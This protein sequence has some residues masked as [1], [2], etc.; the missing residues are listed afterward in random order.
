MEMDR[1]GYLFIF[2]KIP[3]CR[4]NIFVWGRAKPLQLDQVNQYPPAGGPQ[5]IGQGRNRWLEIE[6]GKLDL[7]KDPPLIAKAIARWIFSP[8]RRRNGCPIPPKRTRPC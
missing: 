2:E 7:R 3:V 8:G 4:K 5:Q 1:A 6:I